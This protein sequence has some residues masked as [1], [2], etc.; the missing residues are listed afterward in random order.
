MRPDV[1]RATVLRD[2]MR[3]P[4]RFRPGN[5]LIETWGA[6]LLDKNGIR[7]YSALQRREVPLEVFFEE[8]VRAASTR[9]API[10]LD[11]PQL[12]APDLS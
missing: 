11:L 10:G 5:R 12:N 9:G 3:P 2:A 4:L 7:R 8:F 1:A 6:V